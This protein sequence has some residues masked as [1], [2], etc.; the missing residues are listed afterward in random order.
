MTDPTDDEARRNERRRR[1]AAELI[2]L[3]MHNRQ[4]VRFS[5]ALR[6]AA[7][8]DSG[9]GKDGKDGK[10]AED[11]EDAGWPPEPKPE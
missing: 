8:R 10:D 6:E 9:D 5:E 2:R 3:E 7:R 4:R 1:I 11:V